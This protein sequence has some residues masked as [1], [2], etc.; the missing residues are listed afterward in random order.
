ML[1]DKDREILRILQDNARTPNVEIARQVNLAPS[2]VL[3]RIRTM[4]KEGII[5]GYEAKV[6]C[7]AAGLGMT[8]FVIIHSDEKPGTLKIGEK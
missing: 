8:S 2:A 4:E 3:K 1:D 5:E 6:N 7:L